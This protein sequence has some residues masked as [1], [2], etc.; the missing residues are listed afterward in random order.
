MH[1]S[2]RLIMDLRVPFKDAGAV[3][4]SLTGIHSAMKRLFVINRSC[5]HKGVHVSP[6]VKIY[7]SMAS[8]EAMQWVLLYLSIGHD[9]CY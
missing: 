8:V 2:T 1:A 4:D 5:I 9:T 6:Q 3:A 7:R